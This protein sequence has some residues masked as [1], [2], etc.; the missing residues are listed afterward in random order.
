MSTMK[1]P[2]VFSAAAPRSLAQ[3]AEPPLE[4]RAREGREEL[5]GGLDVPSP[6]AAP[7]SAL[8]PWVWIDGVSVERA[9]ARVS[10]FD[11]G[12][13]YGDSVFETLRTYD[14]RAFALAEHLER[15]ARSARLV[16]IDL[17][18]PLDQLRQEVEA[19]LASVVERPS[20]GECYVRLMLSRGSGALGLD[21]GTAVQPL[22]VMIVAPLTPP[23]PVAYTQGIGVITF[24]TQRVGDATP[25]AGAKVGNYLVAVLAMRQAREHDA[26]EAL[27]VDSAGQVVEGASS[28]LFVVRGGT[29]LTPS[30]REGILP[31]ITRRTLLEVARE[32][33]V[34]VRFE[35]VARE[36]LRLCEEV[37]VSS[38]IREILPVVRIDG[39]PVGAGTPGPLTLRLLEAFRKRVRA[40]RAGQAPG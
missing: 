39:A 14:G 35:T 2:G 16:H 22:R 5:G 30:E 34:E 9:E 21:P 33:G 37:F 29:L 6:Q 32:L 4:E 27:I 7:G 10:V 12:F 40:P 18:V 1:S 15:L 17:P 3:G 25:A 28:N 8:G 24:A 31:G 23:P 13:L 11:R 26:A 36:E 19:A 38:S 20:L